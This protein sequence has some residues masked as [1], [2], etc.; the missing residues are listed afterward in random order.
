MNSESNYFVH[1]LAFQVLNEIAYQFY[2][3]LIVMT[4]D[5]E[6]YPAWAGQFVPKDYNKLMIKRKTIS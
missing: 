5:V 1:V 6:E 3:E 4:L 2:N